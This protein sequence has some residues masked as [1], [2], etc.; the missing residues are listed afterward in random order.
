[1]RPHEGPSLITLACNEGG[2]DH[3]TKTLDLT[4]AE[5]FRS[6]EPP[7]SPVD[8]ATLPALGAERDSMPIAELLKRGYPPRPDAANRPEAY[9]R[10]LSF[11]SRPISVVKPNLVEARTH[12]GPETTGSGS[13]WGG[14]ILTDNGPYYLSDV[15]I[16]VPVIPTSPAAHVVIWGGLGGSG[17][18]AQSALIQNGLAL[19]ATGSVAQYN[20]FYEYWRNAGRDV[21]NFSVRPGDVLEAYAYPTDDNLNWNGVG[22]HGCFGFNNL[23]QG[24][25]VSGICM[26]S[27]SKNPSFQGATAEFII[28]PQA[29]TVPDIGT[30]EIDGY[31]WAAGGRYADMGTD[32]YTLLQL[33]NKAGTNTIVEVNQISDDGILLSWLS[34]NR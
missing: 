1:M 6:I 7:A 8:R 5:T 18:F 32:P 3:V 19:D 29:N 26:A 9:A 28:E 4:D 23:T 24:T 20:A 30:I 22:T 10:W 15:T 21:T 12:A 27:N 34:G 2:A 17:G 13:G 16:H 11:V 33:S 25:S 31:A 14:A